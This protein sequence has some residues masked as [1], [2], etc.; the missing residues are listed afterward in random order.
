MNV[1][2]ETCWIFGSTTTGCLSATDETNLPADIPSYLSSQGTLADRQDGYIPSES[3]SSHQYM[4]SSISG[5]YLQS[6]DMNGKESRP[7]SIKTKTL[8]S[9][10]F[11]TVY[12][13]PFKWTGLCHLDTGSE[14]DMEAAIDPLLCHYQGPISSLLRRDN[15]YSTD[16]SEV[17]TGLYSLRLSFHDPVRLR[18]TLCNMSPSSLSL[19]GVPLTKGRSA[20]SPTAAA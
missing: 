2:L 18:D 1:L 11:L 19:Q 16:P 17:Y 8:S 9:H 10:M 14:T 4:A 3:G 15:I 7:L 5:F 13:L 6:K 20:L 12:T